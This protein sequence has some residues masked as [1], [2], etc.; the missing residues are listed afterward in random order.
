MVPDILP[1]HL[2][3]GDCS[4]AEARHIFESFQVLNLEIRTKSCSH[5]YTLSDMPVTTVMNLNANTLNSLTNE[6]SEVTSC[7]GIGCTIYSCSSTAN[8]LS[9]ENQSARI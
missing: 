5:T 6:A 4:S 2:V 9:F 1:R 8:G 7:N 3:L